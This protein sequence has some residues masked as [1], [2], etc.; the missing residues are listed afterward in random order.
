MIRVLVVDDSALARRLLGRML[1]RVEGFDVVGEASDAY[2]ARDLIVELEPDVVVLDLEM[3][4]MDGISFLRKLMHHHPIPVVVCSAMTKE[5]GDH[6]L[7]ALDAGAAAIVCKVSGPGAIAQMTADL[8][9]AV[10]AAALEG[11]RPARDGTTARATA[12]TIPAPAARVAHPTEERRVVVV[13]ASTGGTIAVEA[14]V[15]KLPADFPPLIIVQHLPQYISGAFAR[16]LDQVAA[17]HV[18]EA[19]DGLPLRPGCALV[20]PGD[21]HVFVEKRGT[22]L[23]VAV[24][25][26]PKIN[27]HRPSVDVLFRSAADTLRA[28]AVGVL[29][30]G[31]GKD[32]AEGLLALRTVGAYTLAQ[33]EASSAVF[34][35]PKAAIELGAADEIVALD[36]M[37]ARL[38]SSVHRTAAQRAA[39]RPPMREGEHDA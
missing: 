36:R 16:R 11:R 2:E 6:A 8:T 3:P 5:G 24:R 37:A 1:P 19:E 17:L 29:L 4:R 34:G 13:G 28:A 18:E 35:M 30:T 31:M 23:V 33:D 25:P 22:A 12:T 27:G 21:R 7:A 9:N 32:G 26:G 20:A 38:T 39:R 14:I 15:R 10:R